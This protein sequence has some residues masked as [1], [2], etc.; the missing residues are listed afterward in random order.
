MN[1]A[2]ALTEF[3]RLAGE[4]L[5]LLAVELALILVLFVIARYTHGWWS[6]V[7]T[8]EELAERDNIAFGISLAGG[9]TGLCLVLSGV[10]H[11]PG[12]E[13]MGWKAAWIGA[14]GLATL[15]LIR[16]GR[17]WYD[18]L[19]LHQVDK[20]GL[21]LEGNIAM[22][23]VDAAIAIATATVLLANLRWL[24]EISLAALF[25]LCLDYFI[26]LTLLVVITRVL[27]HRFKRI[28]Q[29]GSL[30]R[31]LAQDHRAVALRH[32][33]YLLACGKIIATAGA[34]NPY[35]PATPMLNVGGW[36]MWSTIGLALLLALSSG[37]RYVVLA[38]IKVSREVE[39]QNNSGIA[40]LDGAL[41]YASALL[42]ANLIQ[43]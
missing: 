9:M 41:V 7:S 42:L 6:G 20:Q 30:Q 8:R 35:N 32:S 4:S 29:G 24:G 17:W 19:A 28:N 25:L 37:L 26:A 31:A 34:L 40:I 39:L 10:F 36:L 21:I 18:K 1:M 38:Q 16:L 11:L 22:A 12:P 23:M 5:P 2:S 13:S 14:M 43:P 33:A 15:A 27:E 3:E